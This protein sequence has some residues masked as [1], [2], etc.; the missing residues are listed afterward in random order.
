M[1]M[2]FRG[3]IYPATFQSLVHEQQPFYVIAPYYA[4]T[5]TNEPQCDDC[6]GATAATEY[7]DSGV[8]TVA[9]FVD[10]AV[11]G[12]TGVIPIPTDLL[13]RRCIVERK[14]HRPSPCRFK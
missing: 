13:E 1:L 6:H 3:K 14:H 12:P 11:E 8:I 9:T 10:G 2:N 4:H 5:I 7:G